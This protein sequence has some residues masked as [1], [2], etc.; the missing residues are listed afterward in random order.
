MMPSKRPHG[1]SL[2]EVMVATAVALFATLVILQSFAVSEGYRRTSTSG[3]DAT[4]AGALA[5]YSLQRDLSTAGYGINGLLPNG[6][7]IYGCVVSGSD[8]LAGLNFP[9]PFQFTLAPAQITPGATAAQPD[10][11]TIISS[12]TNVLPDPITM[13][14]MIAVTDN[15]NINTP[16]GISAGDLLVL[17]DGVQGCTLVQAT[18]TPS[19]GPVGQQNTI[20]HGTGTYQTTGGATQKARYNPTGGIGPVYGNGGVVMDLGPGPSINTYYIQNNALM[21]NQPVANQNGQT[22]APN[23]VMLKAFYGKDTNGDGIVDTWQSTPAPVT[24]VDWANVYAIRV[25]VVARSAQPERPDATTGLCPTP[26]AP[27]ITWDDGSTLPLD[28]SAN[29]NWQCYRYKVF[30][31]TASMRNLVWTPS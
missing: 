30:H 8:Q 5:T 14:A 19:T 24:A 27:T 22:I 29:A 4:F 2:V 21:L 3:G 12:S 31:M 16:Y 28:L 25:V 9:S 23:V 20:L 7:N 18:N 17:A 6:L 11:I 15:Y 10:Q 13:T 26:V 1:F